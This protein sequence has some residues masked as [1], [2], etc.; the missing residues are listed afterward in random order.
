MVF[1]WHL[2]DLEIMPVDILHLAMLLE[3]LWLIV[4]ST[5]IVVILWALIQIYIC[6]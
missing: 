4:Q 3:Y 2:F 5:F 1:N 6:D